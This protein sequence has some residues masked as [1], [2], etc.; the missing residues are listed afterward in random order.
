M[1]NSKGILHI[2]DVHF[3]C[4]NSFHYAAARMAAGYGAGN[5]GLH[6]ARTG[7][8]EELDARPDLFFFGAVPKA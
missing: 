4:E 6:V 7:R 1:K 2:T 8:G 3:S 5:R